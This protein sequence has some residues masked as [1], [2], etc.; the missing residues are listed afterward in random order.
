M[1]QTLTLIAVI[2]W[3]IFCNAQTIPAPDFPYKMM[4]VKSD[5]T[6]FPL[7]KTMMSLQNNAHSAIGG[8]N[9]VRA[10]SGKA[11]V[12]YSADGESASVKQVGSTS[13]RYIITIPKTIDPS[14]IINLYAFDDVKKGERRFDMVHIKVGGG[15]KSE[16]DNS[17][18]ITITKQSDGVYLITTKSKLEEGEYFFKVTGAQGSG[19]MSDQASRNSLTAFC[20]SVGS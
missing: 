20:F 19:K 17:I 12:Y 8:V 14:D 11:K 9:A 15:K 7:D 1:K 10:F 4:G 18:P 3:A 6:L 5:N 2:F 13:E 16:D